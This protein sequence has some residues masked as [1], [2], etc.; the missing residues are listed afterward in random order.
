MSLI[1]YHL[2]DHPFMSGEA[3]LPMEDGYTSLPESGALE[4]VL[5]LFR[6]KDK[7]PR[8]DSIYVSP[9]KPESDLGAKGNS[10]CFMCSLPESALSQKSDLQWI[11]ELDQGFESIDDL[12]ED[13]AM[14]ELAELANGYWSG[15]ERIADQGLWEIR[16]HESTIIRQVM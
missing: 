2:S 12:L 10:H 6:P 4:A 14:E 9:N 1:C 13:Y 7:L 8:A 5:E 3:I 16:W 11:H 15:K